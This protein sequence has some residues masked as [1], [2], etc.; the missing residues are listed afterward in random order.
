M[1]TTTESPVVVETSGAVRTV[2]LNRPDAMNA[3][4]IATKEALLGELTAAAQDERVRCVVLTGTGRAFCVGQD[5]RE[6]VAG[7]ERGADFLATTVTEHYNPI[8]TLLASMNKPVVTAVNG[9]AAGAGLSFALAGDVRIMV[10]T[11]G[12]NTAFAGIALSCDSGASWWLPRLVGHAR[13][14]DLL[15]FP[16]TIPAPECLELGLV[17]AVVPAERFE[18]AVP[19]G[20]PATRLRS[21]AGLRRHASGRPGQRVDA[22]SGGSRGRGVLHGEHRRHRGPPRGGACLPRQG[23]PGLHGTLTVGTRCLTTAPVTAGSRTAARTREVPWSSAT[24]PT[25]RPR[26]A[27][28]RAPATTAGSAAVPLR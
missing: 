14:K 10:D 13:A 5:L 27:G 22:A 16:R 12:M 20:A 24:D 8:A 15:F 18:S 2:R 23:G 3:L 1:T 28:R 26:R 11:A 6:H 19:G 25:G 4:D 17:T 21:D 7:L 9:V